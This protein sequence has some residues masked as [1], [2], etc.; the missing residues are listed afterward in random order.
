VTAR[1]PHLE[2]LAVAALSKGDRIASIQTPEDLEAL[3]A[4]GFYRV[5]RGPG[6]D[7][8]VTDSPLL[9]VESFGNTATSAWELAEDARQAIHALRGTSVNGVLVDTVSTASGPV[10]VDWGNPG[11][12]RYVASYRFAFRKQFS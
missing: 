3:A 7:D 11:I 5:T 8:G 12:H 6:S 4:T 1:W 2:A 9:D 10:L